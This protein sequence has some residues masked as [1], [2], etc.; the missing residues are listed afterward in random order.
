MSAQ[1]ENLVQAVLNSAKYR[2]VA[3]DLIARI[4]ERELAKGRKFKEAVKATKNKLHQVGAAYHTEPPRYNEWL[5][6]LELAKESLPELKLACKAVMGAHASTRERLPILEQFY[7][8]IFA[9]LPEINSVLDV[10]CGL[11]PLAIPWM[12]L[13]PGTRYFACDIYADMIAFVQSFTEMLPVQGIASICDLSAAPP[14]QPVDLALALKAVPCLEQIDKQAGERL[15]DGLQ[16][17]YLLVSFPAKSLGG[18]NKGM[19]DN[20]EARFNQLTEGRGWQ[21]QKFTFETELAFLVQT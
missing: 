1:L 17:K 8:T 19:L 5:T 12:P 13:Q 21:I 14:S 15:L 18:R 20:Y 16:A 11:N 3:P 7:T 9:Q 6:T 4:G 2:S 10:A